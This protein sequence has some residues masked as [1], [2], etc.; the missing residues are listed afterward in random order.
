MRALPGNLYDGHTLHE[1]LEQIEVLTRII[2]EAV[3]F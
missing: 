1:A 2:H 3:V